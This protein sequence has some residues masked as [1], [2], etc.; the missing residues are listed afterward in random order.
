[1]KFIGRHKELKTLEDFLKKKTASFLVVK[2][3]RRVGKSRLIKEYAKNF[4]HFY[5]FIGLAPDPLTTPQHQIQ[6]FSTQFSQNFHTAP[7]IYRD[8]SDV[9]WALG[10]RVKTGRTLILFDEISWMGSKDPTFLGK[11]K[12]L[13]DIHLKEND[14]L[15]FVL[16][17]SAASW[18]DKHI[19]KSTGFVGRISYTLTLKE[20]SLPECNKFWNTHINPYEKF[21]VLSV[22]GGIPKYLEEINPNESAE[23]NIKKLCFID[24]GLL[25]REFDQIFS[26][27]FTKKSPYYKKIIEILS[28]GNK[29]QFAIKESLGKETFGR[30]PEYLDELEQLGFIARDF[31]WDLSSGKDSKLSMYRISDNYARF[32]LKYIKNLT[33][34]IQKNMFELKS[35]TAL[36]GWDS[37]MGYQFENMML[38]NRQHIHK[39]LGI[40]PDEIIAA[41]PF[42]Q[43]K[44]TKQQG[45]QIDYMIQTTYNTLYVCEIKFS[46]RPI[47][48]EIIESVEKKIQALRVPKGFSIRPVLIFVNGVMEEV[49]DRAYFSNIIDA[50]TFLTMEEKY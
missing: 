35:L 45:C 32:Y 29:D 17:G 7:A 15:V 2:G 28:T 34:R 19:L 22:T 42:F 46:R 5:S 25:V 37:I 13:W 21:K 38:N 8:W 6:E 40:A 23:T 43:R 10:E 27:V 3:R 16:C 36:P 20:L 9:F 31:A 1:M 50:T 30:L 39:T 24:G 14:K 49:I 33:P 18:I 12:N 26:E 44:N 48:I 47:G 11:I 41:N 4:D